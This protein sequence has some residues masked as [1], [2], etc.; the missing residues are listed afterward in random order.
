MRKN[1]IIHRLIQYCV[2]LLYVAVAVSCSTIRELD[3]RKKVETGGKAN[4]TVLSFL[5]KKISYLVILNIIL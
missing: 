4:T 5:P 3:S 2:L 1:I